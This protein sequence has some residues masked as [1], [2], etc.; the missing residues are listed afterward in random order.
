[1]LSRFRQ[2]FKD[3][4][5]QKRLDSLWT[6]RDYL[7]TR[8][9]DCVQRQDRVQQ[10]TL[11]ETFR[12]IIYARYVKD[13]LDLRGEHF[14][15]LDQLTQRERDGY[16]G[17]SYSMVVKMLEEEPHI[18]FPRNRITNGDRAH[19][20]IH[21][22]EWPSK[23]QGLFDWDDGLNRSWENK[24]FRQEAKWFYQLIADTMNVNAANRFRRTLGLHAAR[25]LWI[26]PAWDNQYLGCVVKQSGSKF[27][28][29]STKEYWRGRTMGQ[30]HKWLAARHCSVDL[31]LN[32]RNQDQDQV[33]ID[34]TD[35]KQWKTV[36]GERDLNGIPSGPAEVMR[37]AIGAILGAILQG[38]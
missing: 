10:R 35:W 25:Y 11:L 2:I 24:M 8:F 18:I 31:N 5:R 6:T 17:L 26:I 36:Q 16:W 19:I 32:G 33:R 29:E 7:V 20:T 1:M 28:S 9:R 38:E 4:R 14:P 15:G 34:A 22:I 21:G 37:L 13:F 23:L 30:R 27:H 3:W 12:Q